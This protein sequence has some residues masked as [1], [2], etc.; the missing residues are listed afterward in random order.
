MDKFY[1]DKAKYYDGNMS[2]DEMIISAIED[3]RF[4]LPKDATVTPKYERVHRCLKFLEQIDRTSA[5]PLSMETRLLRK[6]C[7]EETEL[8]AMDNFTE[9]SMLLT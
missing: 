9:Y 4:T 7:L 1:C 8:T 5:I 2:F 6:R 3:G